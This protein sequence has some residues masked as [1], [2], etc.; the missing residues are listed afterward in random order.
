MRLLV[1]F[2][3]LF[4]LAA[5]QMHSPAPGGDGSSLVAENIAVTSLD[6]APITAAT[7]AASTAPKV[8]LPQGSL[9]VGVPAKAAA[10]P[11]ARPQGLADPKPAPPDA[12]TPEVAAEPV[13]AVPPEQVLCEK[14]KGQWSPLGDSSGHVCIHSTRESGKSCHRK[15][16]CQGECLAQSGTC[17]PIMPLMGCN[18]ILQADGSEVT[19]CMQ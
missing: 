12:V 16:D 15:G 11:P 2:A 5:C 13:V 14:S 9:A 1:R 17:S 4:L 8:G 19:L 18:A 3:A 7:L 6:A 10:P